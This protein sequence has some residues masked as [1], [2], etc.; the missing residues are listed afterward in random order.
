MSLARPGLGGDGD[1]FGK[2]PTRLCDGGTLWRP[3]TNSSNHRL[4]AAAAAKLEVRQL[5]SVWVASDPGRVAR[6]AGVKS[7]WEKVEENKKQGTKL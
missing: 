2:Q 3:G 7:E 1:D 5:V 4:A 6:D